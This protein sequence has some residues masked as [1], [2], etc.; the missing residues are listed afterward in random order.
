[1][2]SLSAFLPLAQA[3]PGS[4]VVG[5]ILDELTQLTQVGV[6][7]ALL[8]IAAL[9]VI[10]IIAY[11]IASKAVAENHRSLFLNAVRTWVLHWLLVIGAA[12]CMTATPTT[13]AALVSIFREVS[14]VDGISDTAATLDIEE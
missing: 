10:V 14:G 7:K 4:D 2:Q 13:P 1:M 5:Q 3:A 11:Y 8:G 12:V 6:G 9:Q